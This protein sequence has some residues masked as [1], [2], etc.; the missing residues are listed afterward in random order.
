VTGTGG[1]VPAGC[2]CWDRAGTP[3]AEINE[4]DYSA[5]LNCHQGSVV[6]ADTACDD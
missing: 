6:V 3:G 4:D 5:F 2:E 1:G